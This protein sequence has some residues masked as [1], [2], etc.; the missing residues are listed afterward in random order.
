MNQ[1][2]WTAGSTIAI[3]ALALWWDAHG[4]AFQL[5][6]KEKRFGTCQGCGRK[7]ASCSCQLFH[8]EPEDDE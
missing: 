1:A 2:A 4:K 7:K 8:F 6:Q 3:L 5:R